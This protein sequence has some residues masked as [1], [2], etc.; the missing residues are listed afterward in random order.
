MESDGRAQHTITLCSISAT[1]LKLK[2]CFREISALY[3]YDTDFSLLS[4]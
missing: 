2:Q 1:I 3:I 4:Y